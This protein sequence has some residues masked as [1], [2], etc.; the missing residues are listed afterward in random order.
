MKRLGIVLGAVALLGV[1]VNVRA[2][3]KAAREVTLKGTIL[4]ARC[5]LKETKKCTN[6][7]RVDEDGIEVVYY[8]DDKGSA[9]DYHVEVCGGARK[10]GTVTGKVYVKD[11]KHW[12]KPKKVEYAK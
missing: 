2:A 4:C 3:E 10:E 9:E 1:I 5:A 11:G 12:I 7:I 6:A 8:L